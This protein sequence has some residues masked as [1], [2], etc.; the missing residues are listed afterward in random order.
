M[1]LLTIIDRCRKLPRALKEWQAFLD[2]K[3]TIEEFSECCPLLELMTNKAMM[4]RHWKRIAE[5]S[6]AGNPTADV[7]FS[8]NPYALQRNDDTVDLTFDVK[9]QLSFQD[10]KQLYLVLCQ[11]DWALI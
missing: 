9:R 7:I 8:I 2:L 10:D 4:T 3:K 1:S 5:V 6:E 11:G